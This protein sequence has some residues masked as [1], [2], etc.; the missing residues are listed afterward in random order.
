MGTSLG[1]RGWERKANW[2]LQ[3][4]ANAPESRA[5]AGLKVRRGRVESSFLDLLPISGPTEIGS[6]LWWRGGTVERL[7][8]IIRGNPIQSMAVAGFLIVVVLAWVIESSAWRKQ[9]H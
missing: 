7:L 4:F 6:T 8:D 9:H 5:I 3:G 2:G 1:D